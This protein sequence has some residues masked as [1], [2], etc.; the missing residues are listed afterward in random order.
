MSSVTF[1]FLINCSDAEIAGFER[2]NIPPGE[3]I[4][5]DLIDTWN[6]EWCWSI[7][8]YLLLKA[9]KNLRV[10]CSNK[11]MDGV[12][13][14]VHS[15]QLYE[16][17]GDSAKFIVCTQADFPRRPWAHYHIVQNKA[18]LESACAYIPHWIQPYLVKRDA[19]R[20]GVKTVAY[21]GQIWNGNLAGSVEEWQELF[22]PHGL[23]FITRENGAWNDMSGIDV[24]IG[25]RSFDT[26]PHNTKPPSKLINAWHARIPF[27]GGYDSAFSQVGVP[28]EDYL[29]AKSQEEVLAAVLK[30]KWD[31]KLY[32]QL[33]AN[34]L[35]KAVMYTNGRIG[36]IWE[37][38]LTGAVYERFVQWQS[39]PTFE[40][41]RFKTL[42]SI[43]QLERRSKAL[44]K[45]I[46]QTP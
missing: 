9:R 6:I 25:I 29:L 37:E 45:K 4:P 19:A 43:G 27:I 30:L 34:G 8:T 35:K 24:A 36:T 13:N 44:V 1:N 21:V 15:T 3:D 31:T 17:G 10:T 23:E 28:G 16:L 20:S 2:L 42:L 40:K 14:I 32:D 18:Q 33:V 41:A 12:I 11:L 39:R 22:R 38:V 5:L 7:Q 46:V 26:N